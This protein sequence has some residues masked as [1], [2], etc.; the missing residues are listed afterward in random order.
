MVLGGGRHQLPLVR[1]A[2]KR[3][4]E[5]VLVDYLENAPA[6]DVATHPLLQDALDSTL[7]I[8]AGRRY[9][10][11]GV[12]TTGTDLPVV[13]MADVAAALGLPCW[14]TPQAARTATD[15]AR[16]HAAFEATGVARAGYHHLGPADDHRELDVTFPVVVKPADSQGQRGVTKVD[17]TDSMEAAVE[18]A[19][20]HSATRRVLVEQF[21]AGPV[22]PATAGL[23]DGV[24]ILL[25]DNDRVTFNPPPHIGVAYQHVHPSRHAVDHLEE[26]RG[27]LARVAV[28][29][30]MRQGPLYAQ[31]IVRDDDVRIIEA[32]ARVGG[33]HESSM[34]PLVADGTGVEDRQIDLAL[35]GR[36]R[37]ITYDMGRAEHFVHAAVRFVLGR[38]GVISSLD[39]LERRPAEIVEASWYCTPG[40]TLGDVR[41]SLG[42]IGYYIAVGDDRE[43]MERAA[44]AFYRGLKVLSADGRNLVLEPDP[45]LIN[46]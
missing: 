5:V 20:A 22:V 12:V 4:I 6:R 35:T 46:D 28:A 10:I 25:A 16:M 15:K 26:I 40:M 37:P 8:E 18:L 19:R 24:L 29:Y 39:S 38:E 33:G 1:A 3:G 41:N 21:L 7:A 30:G 36:C 9:R 17:G 11:D 44:D 31:M 32:A 45:A 13:T 34:F 2:E 14:V 43:R 27:Q 42:R 23:L